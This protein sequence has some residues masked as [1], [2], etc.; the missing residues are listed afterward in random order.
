MHL[1]GHALLTV[2][3]SR[4]WIHAEKMAIKKPSILRCQALS[5]VT[6][7]LRAYWLLETA[8]QLAGSELSEPQGWPVQ[9]VLW[10]RVF[11]QLS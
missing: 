11:S 3:N 5:R 2:L 10:Q 1:E 6:L 8:R 7:L 9:R 4:G